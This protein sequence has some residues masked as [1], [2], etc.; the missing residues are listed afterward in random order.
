MRVVNVTFVSKP[1]RANPRLT[2]P[3]KLAAL[4]GHPNKTKMVTLVIRKAS[5]EI[6]IAD[7]VPLRS[8]TEIYGATNV[9][10][11]LK[12]LKPGEEIWVE[13]WRPK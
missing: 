13:A 12:K 10:P 8:G 5:G 9:R 6:L 11:A 3:K 4:L 2:F 1:Q 7:T